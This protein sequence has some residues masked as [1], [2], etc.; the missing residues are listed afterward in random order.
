MTTK[1][2]NQPNKNED[3]ENSE[4]P[5]SPLNSHLSI[6]ATQT[7]LE[8]VPTAEVDSKL[9]LSSSEIHD[10]YYG[11]PMDNIN[12]R[13]VSGKKIDPNHTN[14]AL[15]AGMMLGIRESV[16]GASSLSPEE[17]NTSST[18]EVECAKVQK[19]KIPKG[20]YFISSQSL[21][22]PYRYKFKSYAPEIFSRIRSFSG[23]EKQRFLH[24]ICGND[25][26]IEF[27]SNAKSGQFFFYSHDGRFMI[28]TMLQEEKAFL[29]SILPHYYIHLQGNPHSLLTHFYG[30]YRV[31]IPDLGKSVHFVIM[32][33]VFNT[34]KEIHKIWDL[35]G[36]TLGRKSKRGDAVHKDLDILDEQRKIYISKE[37]KYKIL[38][39]LKRDTGFLSRMNIMDYSMLM[40]VHLCINGK[41]DGQK[42]TSGSFR[43]NTPM[44]RQ[45]KLRYIENGKVS[46]LQY[47]LD[48][49]KGALGWS[50]ASSSGSEDHA[51]LN[52]LS[53][54][55]DDDT[56]SDHDG[57]ITEQTQT[58]YFD[59]ETPELK[60]SLSSIQPSILEEL[61]D[62]P[63]SLRE[64][65]GIESKNGDSEEI[66][67]CGIIDILQLYN[68]RKWGE[69][70]MRKAIGGQ[71]SEIS[72][73]SP[74]MYA[75]RFVN[76]ID[77][78]IEETDSE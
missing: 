67:F 39:Q 60:T 54:E 38:E 47:F 18:L 68:T 44:R 69:T 27:V 45:Q 15:A 77:G 8:I 37:Q 51:E 13:H 17:Q 3:N 29:L 1:Q 14:F 4:S 40:G 75:E 58:D 76:F 21:S 19:L 57:V 55:S 30:M 24:S 5:F 36:S 20:T 10:K 53:K 71:E 63:Y 61:H 12:T 73:V 41:H 32:K 11:A 7:S 64:D 2:S 48:G 26:F 25:T 43:T 49:A 78:I 46:S 56:D 22:I 52:S 28:K 31:K 50:T 6:S 9:L 62:T 72:C 74:D 23:V 16:G 65:F 35:K 70:I 42:S 34:E 33:S 59:D 66:Y